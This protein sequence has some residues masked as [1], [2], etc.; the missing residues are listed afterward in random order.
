MQKFGTVCLCAVSFK[1]GYYSFMSVCQIFHIHIA[2][3]IT[4]MKDGIL[5]ISCGGTN[6]Y[7]A[8]CGYG[9]RFLNN[10]WNVGVQQFFKLLLP[11]MKCLNRY[12]IH[13]VSGRYA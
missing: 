7:F 1:T 4:A 11:G 3:R 6:T 12:A 9:Y 5:F 13:V 8:N 2:T 10:Y